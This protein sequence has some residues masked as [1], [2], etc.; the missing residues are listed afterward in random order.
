[1]TDDRSVTDDLVLY[2]TDGSVGVIT[3]NRPQKLNAIS[4]RLMHAWWDALRTA[5][6]DESTSVVVLRS[7]PVRGLIRDT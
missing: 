5:E 1:M 6:A 4:P 2:E 7:F 3:I